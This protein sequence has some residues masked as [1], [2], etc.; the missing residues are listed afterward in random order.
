LFY[1]A[2]VGRTEARSERGWRWTIKWTAKV[3]SRE[4]KVEFSYK[5]A[6]PT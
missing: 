3:A 2:S 5:D 6:L 1:C 4:V